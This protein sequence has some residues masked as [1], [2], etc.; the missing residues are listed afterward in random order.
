MES[1]PLAWE[2]I[3]A[4]LARVGPGRGRP[5]RPSS[6]VWCG[7]RRVWFDGWRVVFAVVLSD[8]RPF[9][10]DD[11]LPLQRVRCATCKRSWTL[12]P[13]FLHP[14]FSFQPD[15]VEA[16]VLGYL[17]CPTATYRAVAAGFRCSARSLWRWVPWVATVAAPAEIVATAAR[18]QPDTPAPHLIPR[19]VP[20]AHPKAL[21]A[22]RHATLLLALQVLVALTLWARAQVFPPD[23]PSPLRLFVTA[24]LFEGR[25]RVALMASARSPPMP[26]RCRG[27]PE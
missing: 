15:V 11:G 16:A 2:E 7:L 24:R 8:G 14:C 21:S 1:F 27:P 17:S 10:F 19:H 22:E 12:R 3:N 26:Q 6:C 5:P 18:I 20:E 4:Y 23:D 9:R 25:P 13:R